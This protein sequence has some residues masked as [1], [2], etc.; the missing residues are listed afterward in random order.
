MISENLIKELQEI[1]KTRYGVELSFA[2]ASTI[3]NDLVEAFNILAQ[4]DFR[5]KYEKD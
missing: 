5:E 1:V 3:G 2:D 4:I